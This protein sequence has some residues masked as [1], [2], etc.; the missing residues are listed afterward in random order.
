M[1]DSEDFPRATE[2]RDLESCR[3][4]VDDRWMILDLGLIPAR[5]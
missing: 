3:K 5:K 1:A 2:H 4:E